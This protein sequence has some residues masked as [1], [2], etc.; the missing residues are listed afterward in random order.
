MTLDIFE[1]DNYLYTNHHISINTP[2]RAVGWT[3]IISTNQN[4][5]PLINQSKFSGRFFHKFMT[6]DIFELDNYV[7]NQPSCLHRRLI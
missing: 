1:L 6:S 7:K 3:M 5:E 4:T 2:Y